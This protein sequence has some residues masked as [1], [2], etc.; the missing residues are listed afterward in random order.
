MRKRFSA[1][2]VAFAATGLLAQVGGSDT[3]E[4]EAS[5][6]ELQRF[7]QVVEE[8]SG[9]V[10]NAGTKL[11]GGAV[12][13]RQDSGDIPTTM[14]QICC[15]SNL[16]KIE[17][18]F[19]ALATSIKNLRACYRANENVDG[20]VQ[21]NF[22][23]QDALSLYRALGNFTNAE[24]GDV[25]LGYGSMIKNTLLLKKS[26]KKLTECDWYGTP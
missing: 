25:L 14:A 18:Q 8:I 11:K 21:L 16:D 10:S 19:K 2:L 4:P 23:H 20:E 26:A 7:H 3:R 5:K 24:R 9:Q 1:L 12:S 22:V 15:A 6:T 13:M 17:K